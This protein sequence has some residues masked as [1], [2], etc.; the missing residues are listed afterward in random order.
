MSRSKN[1]NTKYS[2]EF[3]ISVI[4]DMRENELSYKATMR[5]Y[6]PQFPP[7]NYNFIKQWERIYLTEGA[8]GFMVDNESQEMYLETIL[9]LAES[10]GGVRAIDIAD[11]LGY[12]KPSVSRAVGIMKKDGHIV[13]R[14][15]GAI[16]L[17]A[18]GR[19]KAENVLCR[20]KSLTA[21]FVKAGLDV[22]AAEENA[23]RVEHVITEEAF[24]ALKKYFEV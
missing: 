2:P 24:E 21:A 22:G 11:E 19:K 9:K 16:E 5:K 4:I 13:V 10:K 23:C 14:S 3:K 6:F 20:H 7:K 15:D 1:F 8:Q 12:S 18:S 17:T